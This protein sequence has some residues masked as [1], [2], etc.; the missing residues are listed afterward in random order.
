MPKDVKPKRASGGGSSAGPSSAPY[1][2]HVGVELHHSLGQH[3]LKNPLVTAAMIEK[4]AIKSTDTVL[5]IGPGTGNLTLKL[6]E[7][8]KKVIAIEHDPRM[9]VELQKRVHGTEFAHKLQ[10]I[11]SD[12]LKVDLPFFNLCV[13]NIPYQISSPLVFKLLSHAPRFRCAILMVQR[14]FALRLCAKAGDELYCRLAV[15]TQLLAKVDHLMKVSKNSFRP[16][17]KVDSSVV[18]IEPVNPPP[19]INFVEWD[20]LVRLCFNRKNKTLS[21]VLKHKPV[22]QLLSENMRTHLAMSGGMDGAEEQTREMPDVKSLVARVLEETE[23]SEARSTKLELDD[24]ML[25]L[26]KFN[27]VGL[28]FSG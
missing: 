17:P 2:R 14:E 23:Y 8:A 11:H 27:E 12:V 26:S 7:I 5:E 10:L 20:G 9:V 28:H 18:R 25:L 6:L 15:N 22:L 21:A 19:P 1:H 3:L 16:P 24:F 13:A 4:A